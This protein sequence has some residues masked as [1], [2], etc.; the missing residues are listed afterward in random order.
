MYWVSENVPKSPDDRI[1]VPAI[2]PILMVPVHR[3][4]PPEL[5]AREV[6]LRLDLSTVEVRHVMRVDFFTE[7]HEV[8]RHRLEKQDD[9]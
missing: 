7:N 6:T 5:D 4:G 8:S 3:E 1:T 9:N 2:D